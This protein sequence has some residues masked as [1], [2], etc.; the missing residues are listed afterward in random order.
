MDSVRW[1]N[2]SRLISLGGVALVAQLVI[3][4]NSLGIVGDPG[5]SGV[6]EDVVSGGLLLVATVCLAVGVFLS[7]R[8]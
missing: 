6:T 3:F 2:G 5:V 8:D 7:L 4:Q 1:K